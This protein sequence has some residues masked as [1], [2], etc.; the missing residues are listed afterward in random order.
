[1]ATP[2]ETLV[3]IRPEYPTP[4][5]NDQLGEML[6]RVAWIHRSDGWGL[7]AKPD[8]ASC[9]QP[10]TGTKIAR[11]ILCIINPNIHYDCLVD[12]EGQAKPIWQNKGSYLT[13]RFVSPVD[14]SAVVPPDNGGTN[15]D[16]P[17]PEIPYNEAYSVEFGLA[18]NEV[19]KETTEPIDPGMIS[20]QSQR[21]AWDYY[22]GDLTWPQSRDK[23]INELRAVYGLPPI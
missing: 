17:C 19:Y 2:Y 5:S 4:M 3:E 11:D 7:L 23:H 18:C 20:V 14:P 8:G 15:P 10:V 13:Q 9:K 1:M 22:V 16:N 6:N 12:A 21:A